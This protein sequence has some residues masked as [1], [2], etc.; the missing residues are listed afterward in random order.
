MRIVRYSLLQA[1]LVV[2]LGIAGLLGKPG[3]AG[4]APEDLDELIARKARVP[5]QWGP[6]PLEQAG[7]PYYWQPEA[8]AYRDVTTGA[9]VW[10]MSTTNGVANYFHQDISVTP[11]SADGKR[12]A[13]VSV[14]DTLAFNRDGYHLWMIVNTDGTLLRPVL[15]GPTRVFSHTAYFHWSPQL[16]ETYYEFG[17]NR[18]GLTGLNISGLYSGT[19]TDTD[20]LRS[21]L[22]A[23]PTDKYV[24][25]KLEKTISA[26]G[27]KVIAM[28]FDETWLYPTTIYPP[29]EV[30]LTDPDGYSVN[31]SLGLWGDTPATYAALHDQYYRGDGGWFFILPSGKHAW[32]RVAVSGSAADGGA[33]YTF[34]APN[35]FGE[36]WPEN[37]VGAWGGTPDPFGSQYWSH[38]TPDRWGR[39]ALFSATDSSP[40]GPGTWDIQ[41]HQYLERTY[42]KASGPGAQHHDWSGFTDWTISSRGQGSDPHYLNDRL[43]VQ[44]VFDAASQKEIC[45][46]HT[47][48]NNNGV[49]Y[50]A[51]YEYGSVPRPSQSPDGTKV[52]FHSTFLNRK[53]GTYDDKPD[54]F[55]AVAYYPLPPTD[56]AAASDGGVRISWLPP[57]YT[58]RGWP[59]ATKTPARDAAGWPV[60]DASGKELG[61]P[62]YAREVRRYHVWRSATGT[63]GWTEVGQVGAQYSA[64]YA[65]DANLFML[66]P[67]ANGARVSA[68][69]K[70]SWTDSV[71]DGVHYYAVTTEEHSGLESDR[72]SEVLRVTVSGGGVAG[73]SVVQ[74]SGQQDF[75]RTAPPP[76]T[77]LTVTGQATAGQYRLAWTEPGDGMIRYYNVYYSTAGPPAVDQ[78]NRIASVP[79]GTTSWL[80]WNAHPSLS[81]NYRV[82]SVDRHGNESADSGTT[83]Q[84]P[85]SLKVLLPE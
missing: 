73:V 43:F 50:G 83:M 81:A 60:L 5:A 29:A 32:W 58:E 33:R 62:L 2:L 28:T 34:T 23:Y 9:E 79:V 54:I 46:T 51:S 31:R 45:Y 44:N 40:L 8:V 21:L 63:G 36:A 71:T 76:P 39:Y 53:S 75:W 27:R 1:V 16:P 70:V 20:V 61:E 82:T 17:R 41:R 37:T 10:R 26:D 47:L 35:I 85:K 19:V 7:A 78:R 3:V 59:Y 12:M 25:K 30:G 6:A 49:Y 69:N 67:I 11:W 13:F 22:A 55:W 74:A 57:K 48:Y 24:E 4:A 18:G 14:R 65:E 84:S 77:A 72:L 56:L 38:F 66:H 68:G 52:A 80:D 42:A 15:N 64:T